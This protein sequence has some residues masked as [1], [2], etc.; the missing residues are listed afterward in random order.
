VDSERLQVYPVIGRANWSFEKQ[1]E[2]IALP[3]VDG[4]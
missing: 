3:P 2:Q 4:T 1:G